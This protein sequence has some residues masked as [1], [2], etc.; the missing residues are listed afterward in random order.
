MNHVEFSYILTIQC[1]L[2]RQNLLC[3]GWLTQPPLVTPSLTLPSPSPQPPLLIPSLSLIIPICLL[4]SLT[5]HTKICLP[6]SPLQPQTPHLPPLS[7]LTSPSL[8]P[9]YLNIQSPLVPPPPVHLQSSL[10]SL[11]PIH[12]PLFF[13]NLKL[14][15]LHYLRLIYLT[16]LCLLFP[17]NLR[18]LL[19][20]PS[21]LY[22]PIPKLHLLNL[23]LSPLFPP[24]LTL[25]LSLMMRLLS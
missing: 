16:S 23:L 11:L 12:F 24:L 3:L 5:F 15:Y 22:L 25:N 21:L 7:P 1:H 20:N 13:P 8:P 10:L 9:P 18:L 6:R 2:T 4:S 14:H 19:A 17:L